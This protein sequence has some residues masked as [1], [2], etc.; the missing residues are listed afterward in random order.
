M[1]FVY[2][3]KEKLCNTHFYGICV[4]IFIKFYNFCPVKAI[5]DFYNYKPLA[6]RKFRNFGKFKLKIEY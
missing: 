6:E 3:I 2:Q 1:V 4:S 5:K